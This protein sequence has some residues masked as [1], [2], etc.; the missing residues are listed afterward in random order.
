MK[1]IIYQSTYIDKQWNKINIKKVI[2]INIPFWK[3]L[4]DFISNIA[5]KKYVR[6][7]QK[8]YKKNYVCSSFKTLDTEVG[9]ELISISNTLEQYIK[10]DKTTG[11]IVFMFKVEKK[12][13]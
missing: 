12:E 7:I 8:D 1:Q 10:R 11:D 9:V 13:N 3:G 2:N 4:E 5:Y 6:Y